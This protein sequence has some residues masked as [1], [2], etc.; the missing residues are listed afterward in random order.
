[1]RARDRGEAAGALCGGRVAEGRGGRQRAMAASASEVERGGGG[2]R[3]G[4]GGG[5]ERRGGELTARGGMEGG[6][7]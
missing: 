7:G 5:G 1:V 6:R 4:G 2:E 3:R